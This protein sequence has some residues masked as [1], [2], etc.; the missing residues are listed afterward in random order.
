MW[1]A[2]A[3]RT[4]TTHNIEFSGGEAELAD[5]DPLRLQVRS[6]KSLIAYD[7][8]PESSALRAVYESDEL[9]A[10]SARPWASSRS[11]ASPTRS[12]R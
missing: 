8:I 4:E 11:F 7:Q 2:T 3:Y 12:A 10:S 6:A 1:G 9:T 5:D